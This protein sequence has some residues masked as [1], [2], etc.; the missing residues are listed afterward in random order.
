[1][2]VCVCVCVI[3]FKEEHNQNLI[4]KRGHHAYTGSV[5]DFRYCSAQNCT[6]I[7][8][9]EII[10][11]CH[12]AHLSVEVMFGN[13]STIYSW[14]CYPYFGRYKGMFPWQ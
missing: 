5:S 2:C 14:N 3:A 1:M 12:K 13:L 11:D 9:A 6:A 10:M 8:T 7:I 4:F